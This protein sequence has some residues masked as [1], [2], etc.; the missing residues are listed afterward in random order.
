LL[1]AASDGS[2]EAEKRFALLRSRLSPKEIQ[3]AEALAKEYFYS[4]DAIGY[5]EACYDEFNL[6]MAEKLP[7]AVGIEA[8]R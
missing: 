2:E 8:N 4:S 5:P 1:V 7:P 3:A 6:A